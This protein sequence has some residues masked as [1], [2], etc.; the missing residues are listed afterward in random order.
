MTGDFLRARFTCRT[1]WSVKSNV[2]L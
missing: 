1:S 2:A